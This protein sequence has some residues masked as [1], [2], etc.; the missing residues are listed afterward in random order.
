LALHPLLRCCLPTAAHYDCS[1]DV[2][3]A[4]PPAVLLS[5]PQYRATKNYKSAEYLGPRIA[6]KLIFS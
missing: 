6:D 5:C 3:L 2:L 4:V 1:I